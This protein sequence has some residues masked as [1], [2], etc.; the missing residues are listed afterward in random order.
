MEGGNREGERRGRGKE[1]SGSGI[2]RDRKEV[3]RVR[4]L[5][6]NMQQWGMWNWG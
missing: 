5:N 4:K 2:E 6:R 3:Q 1:E